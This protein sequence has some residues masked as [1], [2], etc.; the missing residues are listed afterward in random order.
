LVVLEVVYCNFVF[1]VLEEKKY[2]FATLLRVL[3]YIFY[4]YGNGLFFIFKFIS[5]L[6]YVFAYMYV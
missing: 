3:I 2:N 4:I 5:I 6:M 1:F